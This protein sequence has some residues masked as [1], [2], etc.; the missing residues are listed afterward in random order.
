ML[1][2]VLLLQGDAYIGD[3][4]F[5]RGLRKDLDPLNELEP[6]VKA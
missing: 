3:Q 6:P 4:F 2:A 5:E 1:D